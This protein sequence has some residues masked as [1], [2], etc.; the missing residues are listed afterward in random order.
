MLLQNQYDFDKLRAVKAT[1]TTVCDGLVSAAT[2][3]WCSTQSLR[4]VACQFRVS[5][6][7]LATLTLTVLH[8]SLNVCVRYGRTAA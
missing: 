1:S 6:T 8:L 4:R 2:R 7:D 5:A 3:R